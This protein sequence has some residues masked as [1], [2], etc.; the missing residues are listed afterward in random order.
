[1]R[2]SLWTQAIG[3]RQIWQNPKGVKWVWTLKSPH[4]FFSFF[5]FNCKHIFSIG[6]TTPSHWKRK[7]AYVQLPAHQGRPADS[8]R[9]SLCNVE[10]ACNRTRGRG[11]KS[12]LGLV[13]HIT[14][15]Q[16]KR[17]LTSG[18]LIQGGINLFIRSLIIMFVCC[19]LNYFIQFG[20]LKLSILHIHLFKYLKYF[21]NFNFIG[22]PVLP[23]YSPNNS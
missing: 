20:L 4:S 23:K 1:M 15:D 9:R 16:V 19:Y 14:S 17:G 5:F 22:F 12:L 21:L 2:R 7:T 8:T 18:S 10:H 6:L 11:V 3:G 13:A